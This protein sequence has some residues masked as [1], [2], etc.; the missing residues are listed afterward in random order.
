MLAMDSHH[1]TVL[2]LLLPNV[3]CV[4]LKFCLSVCKRVNSHMHQSTWNLLYSNSLQLSI[5]EFMIQ[6]FQQV[7]IAN[8]SRNLA[9][10]TVWKLGLLSNTT[11]SF[12][13]SPPKWNVVHVCWKAHPLVVVSG[14][15][16][17]LGCY[18]RIKLWDVFR[19][20]PHPH[21]FCD[22]HQ[23]KLTFSIINIL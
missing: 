23:F 5:F 20:V 7:Q 2:A 11:L 19:H 17:L 15:L 12:I 14:W 18:C 3:Q 4:N 16:L 22:L 13:E 6:S 8:Q 10:A 21:F 1:L 9:I